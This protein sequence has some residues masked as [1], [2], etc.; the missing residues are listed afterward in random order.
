MTPAGSLIGKEGALFAED[1]DGLYEAFDALASDILAEANSLYILAY[2]SPKR[3]GTHV[4]RTGTWRMWDARDARDA[5]S[6]RGARGALA[7]PTQGKGV[8][9]PGKTWG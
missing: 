4:G 6:A 8:S 3:A 9:P 5:W 2:C 1:V 7:Q